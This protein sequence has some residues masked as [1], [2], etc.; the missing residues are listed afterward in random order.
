MSSNLEYATFS[1][2]SGLRSAILW[3]IVGVVLALL[4]CVVLQAQE[5]WQDITM[6]G[7]Y[8]SWLISSFHKG[9]WPA[10]GCF[11]V[12]GCSAWAANAPQPPRNLVVCLLQVTSVSIILWLII[13]AMEITPRRLKGIEHPAIYL[14]E[15]LVLI[16]P[17]MAVAGL[18]TWAAF[19][20]KRDPGVD[21]E[22]SM[23]P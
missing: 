3:G 8:R 12:L 6:L 4:A 2:R 17:P 16:V 18:S 1:F 9:M 5:R 22:N 15:F 23:K 13:G 21:N 19:A 10:L 7:E 20:A 11:I 14:S